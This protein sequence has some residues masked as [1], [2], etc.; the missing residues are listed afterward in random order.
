MTNT[1]I[2]TRTSFAWVGLFC[3]HNWSGQTVY[4]PGPN[5]LLQCVHPTI[6]LAGRFGVWEFRWLGHVACMADDRIP[7]RI[8][9]GWL[10]DHGVKL[11]WHDKAKQDFKSFSISDLTWY[12]QVQDRT[13]WKWL[14]TKG[15]EN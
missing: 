3:C 1:D 7:K 8:L 12:H 11:R 13:L 15:L 9:F 4:A 10:P 5:I 6:Q 2:I 14:M